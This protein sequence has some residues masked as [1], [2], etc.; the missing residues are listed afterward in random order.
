MNPKHQRLK[1][2]DESFTAQ[3]PA[4]PA[5]ELGAGAQEPQVAQVTSYQPVQAVQIPGDQPAQS[6]VHYPIVANSQQQPIPQRVVQY[7]VQPSYQAPMRPQGIPVQQ[8]MGVPRRV[9]WIWDIHFQKGC[10]CMQLRYTLASFFMLMTIFHIEETIA[11]FTEEHFFFGAIMIIMLVIDTICIWCCCRQ[12][13]DTAKLVVWLLAVNFF[14]AVL[15]LVL[16]LHGIAL[17]A[18]LINFY[19]LAL[20]FSEVNRL[21]NLQAGLNPYPQAQIM[22]NQPQQF[23]QV[24]QNPPI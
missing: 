5:P 19:M 4:P 14:F 6:P 1:E 20:A 2:E 16:N 17:L 24:P 10:F 23:Q 12:R 7:H 8:M 3:P 21:L 22:M 15:D 9:Y 18:M 11:F 13:I